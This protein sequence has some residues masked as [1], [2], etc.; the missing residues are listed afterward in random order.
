ML[1]SNNI[2]VVYSDVILVLRGVS[3]ALPDGSILT[4]LGANGAGKRWLVLSERRPRLR[5][6]W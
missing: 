1:K 6:Q 5:R 2:E 4:L 3:L